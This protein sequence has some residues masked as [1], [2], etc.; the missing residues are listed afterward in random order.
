MPFQHLGPQP[1]Q[2]RLAPHNSSRR[3]AKTRR[4]S[5]QR[6]RATLRRAGRT[7]WAPDGC[8]DRARGRGWSLIS[9][10]AQAALVGRTLDL[11]VQK[12][13]RRG[14]RRRSRVLTQPA[15]SGRPCRRRRARRRGAVASGHSLLRFIWVSFIRDPPTSQATSPTEPN[16]FVG[17]TNALLTLCKVQ[18]RTK[19][20]N[21]RTCPSTLRPR[22]GPS[23]PQGGGGGGAERQER[24]LEGRG[25]PEAGARRP[26]R[27]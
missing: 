2:H 1:A 3:A 15:W 6:P 16:G 7:S 23:G 25:A 10:G 22:G 20:T 19:W 12:A 24:V 18:T 13:S 14:C 26:S 11:A 27:G 9:H 8:G 17:H 21:W 5:W 4:R